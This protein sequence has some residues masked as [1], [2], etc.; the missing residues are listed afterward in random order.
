MS[1]SATVY[2]VMI[3]SPSDVPDEREIIRDVVHEW[4]AVHAEHHHAILIPAGWETHSSPAMGE[5][6]QGIINKQVLADCDLLIAAFW[7]RLGSPT[8]KAP[9][10]T[11]EEIQEHLAAGKP[12]MLYFSTAPVRLGSVDNEQYK[13]LETFKKECYA[14]GLIDTYDSLEEFRRKLVRQLAHT[15][16][17]D[18][19]AAGGAETNEVV[20]P[21][22]EPPAEQ[23]ALSHA[24]LNKLKHELDEV[25]ASAKQSR[26]MG[27]TN[28]TLPRMEQEHG[29]RVKDTLTSWLNRA[30]EEASKVSLSGYL[31]P[32]PELETNKP[33]YHELDKFARRQV[34]AVNAILRQLE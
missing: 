30:R 17:R 31:A 22:A 8:G 26:P 4:N 24:A 5:R 9:S 1:F 21:K 10:G 20:R 33:D 34:E 27:G 16:L 14:K 25:I 12:A 6:P 28:D 7:T 3:A 2:K 29:H 19:L 32:A 23:R 13:A 11:V 15:M 18:V